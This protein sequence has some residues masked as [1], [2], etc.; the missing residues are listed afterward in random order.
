MWLATV[1]LSKSWFS[2]VIYFFVMT[3]SVAIFLYGA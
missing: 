1:A 2:L 3:A